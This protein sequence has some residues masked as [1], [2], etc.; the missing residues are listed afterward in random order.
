MTIDQDLYEDRIIYHDVGEEMQSCYSG[1]Q[2]SWFWR[3]TFM[4]NVTTNSTISI[5]RW[6]VGF[7]KSF[8]NEFDERGH[9]LEDNYSIEFYLLSA[10]K[11]DLD[12]AMYIKLWSNSNISCLGVVG[13]CEDWRSDEY[14]QMAIMVRLIKKA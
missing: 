9:V 11:T 12:T 14:F 10:L 7:K 1:M 4:E 2:D 5:D 8:F 6:M 13:H 3:Y